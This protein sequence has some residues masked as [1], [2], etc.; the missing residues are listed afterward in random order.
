M[1]GWLLML[2]TTAAA[3]CGNYTGLESSTRP[4]PSQASPSPS[5]PATI[6]PCATPVVG[7]APFVSTT[8][9]TGNWDLQLSINDGADSDGNAW[10]LGWLCA[11]VP[12]DP[13]PPHEVFQRIDLSAGDGDYNTW[14]CSDPA[15]GQD[16]FYAQVSGTAPVCPDFSWPC[17]SVQRPPPGR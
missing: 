12:Q 8:S 2:A 14:I 11:A 3:A 10:R 1:R 16:T 15:T 5:I 9:E 7:P 4:S 13:N 6:T 17:C